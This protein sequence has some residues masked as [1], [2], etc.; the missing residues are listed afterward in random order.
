MGEKTTDRIGPW[1]VLSARTA[2]D[3]PWIR[4]IDH[5]VTHPDGSPGEYGVVHFKNRAIGVLP[6]DEKGCVPLVGQHRF[7]L[8]RYSWE[9][10]EGG[11]KLETDPLDAAKRELREETG[12][13]AQSW[14][15]LTT[16]DI[17]NSVTDEQA[18]CYLAWDLKAGRASP[19]PSEK[20][21][22]K[23][24]EFI[25]LFNMVVAGE[26]TDS[27]TII[28]TLAAHAKAL[29]GEAPAP[30]SEFILKAR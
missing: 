27:M 10:P 13:T 19:D 29:R 9:L 28:M 24:I 20:I 21:T 15:P 3:N 14:A 7:P 23:K 1:R 30:I 12:F 22:L 5:A 11:G 2:F 25:E 17:S 18:I 6:I 4:I 8:D 26:I 16:F